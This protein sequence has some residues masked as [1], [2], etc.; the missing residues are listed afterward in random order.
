MSVSNLPTN[1]QRLFTW[2]LKGEIDGHIS[3]GLNVLRSLTLCLMSFCGSLYLQKE[4]ASVAFLSA[5]TTHLT[6]ESTCY[7]F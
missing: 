3:F 1:I 6:E 4:E 7:G 2:A 5:M